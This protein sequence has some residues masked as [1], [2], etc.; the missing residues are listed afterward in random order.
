[1]TKTIRDDIC[2]ITSEFMCHVSLGVSKLYST[3]GFDQRL[4]FPSCIFFVRCCYFSVSAFL[5]PMFWFVTITIHTSNIAFFEIFLT[6]LLIGNKSNLFSS[7]VSLEIR[8]VNIFSL[9]WVD[10]Y[11][12]IKYLNDGG[13]E[14]FSNILI[15]IWFEIFSCFAADMQ[16]FRALRCK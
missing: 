16:G 4:S 6:L 14:Y 13:N 3:D 10:S 1:M 15:I 11:A 7:I 12:L 5:D 8:F 9:G 2:S